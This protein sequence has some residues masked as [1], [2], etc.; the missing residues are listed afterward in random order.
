MAAE[1]RLE[2]DAQR[3]VCE[4]RRVVMIGWPAVAMVEWEDVVGEGRDKEAVWRM[5]VWGMDTV[6]IMR[7]G[8]FG[9]GGASVGCVV[10]EKESLVRIMVLCFYSAMSALK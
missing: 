8:G 10:S 4:M 6:M 1:R 3:R 2:G 5:C 7:R 9:D